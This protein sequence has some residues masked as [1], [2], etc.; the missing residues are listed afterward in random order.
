[1]VFKL[2]A[3]HRHE[4]RREADG[5]GAVR[6]LRKLLLDLRH[7]AVAADAVGVHGL[8]DL[9]EEVRFLETAA[10]AGNT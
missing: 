8:R 2:A 5:D 1:M 6:A 10:R 9:C 3:V 4:M 7:V